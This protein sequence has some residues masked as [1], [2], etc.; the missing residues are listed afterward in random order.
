[1]NIAFIAYYTDDTIYSLNAVIAALETDRETRG[2]DIFYSNDEKE[3]ISQIEAQLQ[4]HTI[5][6]VGLSIYTTQ[7]LEDSK[8]IKKIRKK[9]GQQVMIIAGGPHPSGAPKDTLERGVDV[10]FIGE[11]EES[12]IEFVRALQTDRNYNN[13]KGIAYFDEENKYF[14]DKKDHFIDLDDYPPFPLKNTRFG[15]IEIARGCPYSCN[16]CQTSFMIGTKPRYRSV[17]NI[18][19][20]TKIV[21]EQFKHSTDIRFILPNA[22]SYGSV[23][24]KSVNLS[25]LEELLSNVRDIIGKEGRIF[26]GSFPSEVRPEHVNENTLA[27]TKKYAHNDNIIIGAQSGSQRMLDF[28]N[29]GHSVEDVYTAVE[30]SSKFDILPNVDFIFGLPGENEEDREKTIKC[31]E[32]LIEMGARIHAHF[33]I[34]MPGTPFANSP[35]RGLDPTIKKFLTKYNYRGKVYGNWRSQEKLAKNLHENSIFSPLKNN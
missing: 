34:P 18:C 20:Y 7:I 22:F 32:D 15:A 33:F 26:F 12:I 28:C 25:K 2:I 35:F 13:I 8:L 23:D 30:L 14:Y 17:E 24:G 4:S 11:S 29:R 19:K 21:E 10:A 31:M 6:L 3:L 9:F 27:L 16:F 5:V 1:L